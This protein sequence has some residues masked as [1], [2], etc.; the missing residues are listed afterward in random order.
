MSV[1]CG[2]WSAEWALGLAIFWLTIGEYMIYD[3]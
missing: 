1:E 2:V 3:C